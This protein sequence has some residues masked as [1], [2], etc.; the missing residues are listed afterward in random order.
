MATEIESVRSTFL[1]RG[2]EKLRRGVL[3]R[4]RIVGVVTPSGTVYRKLAF[5]GSNLASVGPERH[6]MTEIA[7]V[8]RTFLLRGKENLGRAGPPR[9]CIV[10]VVTRSGT[11]C[12]KLASIGSK[13]A[14]SAPSSSGDSDTEVDAESGLPLPPSLEATHPFSAPTTPTELGAGTLLSWY[15]WKR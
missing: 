9:G 3:P 11:V 8:R 15:C 10:R 5:V 6:A 4:G 14:P 1:L 7:S 12:R 2:E 13:L